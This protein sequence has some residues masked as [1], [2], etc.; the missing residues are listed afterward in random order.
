MRATALVVLIL[1]VMLILL[2]LLLLLMV[3]DSMRGN[4]RTNGPENRTA[5]ASHKSTTHLVARE[6]ASGTAEQR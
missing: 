5:R 6:A 2:M 1:L 3:L 4:V